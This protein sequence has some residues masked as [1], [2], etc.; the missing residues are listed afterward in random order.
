MSFNMKMDEWEDIYNAE[1][2]FLYRFIYGMVQDRNEADDILQET[3]YRAIKHGKKGVKNI[4]AYLM[5]ISR[6]IIYDKWR[7][8]K[9]EEGK[10]IQ[11]EDRDTMAEERIEIERA[12]QKLSPEYR[13]V[14]ILREMNGLNYEEISQSLNIPIGTVK[15]RLNR[16]RLELRET[17]RRKLEL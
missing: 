4:R 11:V 3:F 14:F 16:A 17:L 12:I 15:S 2:G 6:N 1:A 5:R 8:R 13:E 7:R 9:K 10:A